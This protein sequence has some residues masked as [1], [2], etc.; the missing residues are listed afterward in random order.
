MK[1]SKV[2]TRTEAQKVIAR[3]LHT[4]MGETAYERLIDDAR[5]A[6]QSLE[7]TTWRTAGNLLNSFV[8]RKPNGEIPDLY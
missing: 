7:E 5:F 8:V 2:K 4:F 1:L 3:L 6:H